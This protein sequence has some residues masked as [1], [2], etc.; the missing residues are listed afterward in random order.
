MT[1]RP[2]PF[3]ADMVRA[4]LDGRKTQTRRVMRSQPADD[5]KALVPRTTH[6]GNVLWGE[7]VGTCYVQ[8]AYRCPYGVVGDRLWVREAWRT[9]VSLDGKNATQI[10]E[11]ANEAGYKKP[12]YCP[13][14]YEADGTETAW[15]N[16]DMQDFGDWGR[17]RHARFMPRWA[18]RIDLEIV[19]IRVERV[20]EISE[21]DAMAEGI[22]RV[23]GTFSC[24][25]W[26][27]YLRG[28]P[29][30]MDME[31]SCPRRSFQ[32]L[33]DSINGAKPGWSWADNPYVWVVEFTEEG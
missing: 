28:T 29:G 16:R 3:S 25:P 18:S 13:I 19:G 8:S 17:Y 5:V 12:H 15:G 20:Q 11:A 21:A 14:K 1:E 31:C 7:R 2:I 9:R 30:E 24:C 6:A 22:E 10:Q 4:I 27:N 32:T 23:G 26:R 33:W